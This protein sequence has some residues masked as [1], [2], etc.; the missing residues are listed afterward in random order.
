MGKKWKYLLGAG[1]LALGVYAFW[2]SSEKTLE[3][4]VEVKE[5]RVIS[6]PKF[7]FNKMKAIWNEV[8]KPKEV[9]EVVEEES[10]LPPCLRCEDWGPKV[11]RVYYLKHLKKIQKVM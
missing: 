8:N 11:K 6:K 2:P 5:E 1:A 7:D 3:D 10:D 9:E 4:K